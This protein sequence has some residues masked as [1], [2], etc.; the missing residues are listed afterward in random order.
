MTTLETIF[1]ITQ[2]PKGKNL[3]DDVDSEFGYST[4][5]QRLEREAPSKRRKIC[6]S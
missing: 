1:T 6:D 2:T 4:Y 5:M 3:A